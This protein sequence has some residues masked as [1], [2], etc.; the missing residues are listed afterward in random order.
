MENV[1][2]GLVRDEADAI[3]K[4]YKFLKSDFAKTEEAEPFVQ[5]IENI[6]RD[7]R[8]HLEA[9]KFLLDKTTKDKPVT[10]ITELANR[11]LFEFRE[12]NRL[13]K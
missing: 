6:I 9:L 1:I 11:V 3:E 2:W 12:K 5:I 13:I 8:D 4:Y 10:D 7:E